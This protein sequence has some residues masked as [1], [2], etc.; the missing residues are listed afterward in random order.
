LKIFPHPSGYPLGSRGFQQ[1]NIPDVF[2]PA[3]V[4]CGS[5]K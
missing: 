3:T 2:Y 1:L 5:N 4:L